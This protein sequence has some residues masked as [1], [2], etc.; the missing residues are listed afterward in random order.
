MG[1]EREVEIQKERARETIKQRNR[2]TERAYRWTEMGKRKKQGARKDGV[3]SIKDINLDISTLCTYVQK[4]QFIVKKE[5][6]FY[7][8]KQRQKRENY[9]R[10][11]NDKL[12]FR[13][14]ESTADGLVVSMEGS[15]SF[16]H[17]APGCTVR[18]AFLVLFRFFING[19]L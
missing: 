9:T 2:D 8:E 19:C 7:K 13:F 15:C 10:F 16:L 1:R 3:Y 14:L 18:E 17:L 6:D 4:N 5:K 11:E 12:C